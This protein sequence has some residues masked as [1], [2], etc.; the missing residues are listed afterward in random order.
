MNRSILLLAV[1]SSAVVS[2]V[3]IFACSNSS[4]TSGTPLPDS[5]TPETSMTAEASAPDASETPPMGAATVEAWLATGAYKKWKCE[6]AV[7]MARSPSPHGFNRICSNDVIESTVDSPDPWSEGAAAVKELY[8]SLT[9]T[10]PDGY[11]VYLKTES[12]SAGGANWYWF[13]IVPSDSS[14]PHNEAGVVADGLGTADAGPP[15]AICVSCHGA[16]GSNAAHTPSPNGHD[17][18]YT[19]V[20]STSSAD[21]SASEASTPEA[22]ADASTLEASADAS[23]SD[24]S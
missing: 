22:S 24:G 9:A 19:P 20:G 8:S 14:A 11:A 15:Y 21:A 5:S 2:S 3:L 17:F 12:S 10:T 4:S 1:L 23:T 16:A 7:H 6:P 18:V 13:E